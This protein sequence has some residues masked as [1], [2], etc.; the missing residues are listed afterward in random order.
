MEL[1]TALSRFFIASFQSRSSFTSCCSTTS[2]RSAFSVESSAARANMAD[3]RISTVTQT[4][5]IASLL[6]IENH[7]C[8]RTR[9]CSTA[10]RPEDLL[11]ERRSLAVLPQDD[12]GGGFV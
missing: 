12:Y 11:T 8:P 9:R 5:L 6:R 1:R 2:L 4:A 7:R 3:T 10:G